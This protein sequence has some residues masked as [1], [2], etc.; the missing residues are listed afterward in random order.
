MTV[1]LPTK[2]HLSDALLVVGIIRLTAG[3]AHLK[4]MEG[5]DLGR[6]NQFSKKNRHL[7]HE[8][9]NIRVSGKEVEVSACML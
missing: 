6:T 8:G 2:V 9:S 3:A 1:S 4:D 7:L 5:K